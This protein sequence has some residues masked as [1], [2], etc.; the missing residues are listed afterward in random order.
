[1]TLPPA[2]QKLMEREWP[3][4]QWPYLR[5][6]LDLAVRETAR[7]CAEACDKKAREGRIHG[8]VD[9]AEALEAASVYF[10]DRYGVTP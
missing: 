2:V 5:N 3:Q 4:S 10:R 1:M 8:H 9:G 6:I 7:A